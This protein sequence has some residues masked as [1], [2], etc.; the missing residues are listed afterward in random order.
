MV[1]HHR[2]HDGGEQ[3]HVDDAE[4]LHDRVRGNQAGGKHAD[5]AGI[6]AKVQT[7]LISSEDFR[8]TIRAISGISKNGI[9][10]ALI[11]PRFLSIR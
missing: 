4:G 8:R 1:H 7:R 10:I 6:D 2:D 11:I 9:A 3:N 5:D